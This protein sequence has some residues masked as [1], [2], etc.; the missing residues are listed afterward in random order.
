MSSPNYGISQVGYDSQRQ[1]I[2]QVKQH[3]ITNNTA[4][5]GAIVGRLEVVNN[6]LRNLTY[7]TMTWGG[8]SWNLREDVRIFNMD[9]T[10]YIRT[11]NNNTP[12]DNL[13]NLPEF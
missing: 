4:D 3:L 2:A 6:L 11:D 12:S 7:K 5:G 1:H 10:P 13:G 9:G 8:Q